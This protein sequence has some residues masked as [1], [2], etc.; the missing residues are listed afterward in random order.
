[1]SDPVDFGNARVEREKV[2]R[3]LLGTST[4]ASVAKAR[5]FTSMGFAA[6]RWEDLATALREQARVAAIVAMPSEWGTKYIA[7]GEID[8]PN[9]RRYK[10]VSIWIAE[11]GSLRL[12][13]AYPAKG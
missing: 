9:G 2:V 1:M 11:A 8:A 3:Y 6:N 4:F 13:T 5:F 7:T 12:V 10:I